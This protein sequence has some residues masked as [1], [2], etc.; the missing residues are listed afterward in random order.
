M[1]RALEGL[2]LFYPIVPD[3]AWLERLVPLG[4]RTVQL[5]LKDAAPEV[6]RREIA[7][8]LEAC[9]R[10][11]CQLIVNDYWRAALDAGADFVH[12]G[13]EDLAGADIAALHA[14]GV[15]LGISTHSPEELKI[16]LAARPAYVALGPVYE[17]R[18]K[19]MKWAPQGLDRIA[20]W[21]RRIGAL[22]LVAIGGLTPERAD[23]VM[24]AGADSVAV[25]TDF[26]THADPEARVR[27]WLAHTAAFRA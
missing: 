13:Q 10:H 24:A 22:P 27:Q 21:R 3:L 12:L 15:R 6:V 5:R 26:L 18:L 17:T 2:D 8:A 25:V 16:A 1:T 20:D 11:D 7:G 14:A 19:V 23:A 9:A 4:V